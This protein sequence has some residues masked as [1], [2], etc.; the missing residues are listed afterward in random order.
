MRILLINGSPKG[1]QSST[2]SITRAFI[3]GM[4]SVTKNEVQYLDVMAN[5]IEYC[6]G[7]LSCMKN[8]G[9]CIHNDDMAQILRDILASELLLFS[10]PLYGFGVPAPLK[11]LLDR[12]LPLGSLAMR[13][14]GDRYEHVEQADF[15]HLRYAVISG[16]GF[17]NAKHN[18]DALR[19][20]FELRFPNG[21]FVLTVP[22]AP[23]FSAPE[24]AVVTVPFLDLVRQAG[25]EYALRGTV[26]D[27]LMG[28]LS[29]P[30][31]PEETYAAI[32]NG[33]A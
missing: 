26:S 3:D 29:V 11:A 22:E 20:Q 4:S 14:S 28:K 6:R 1:E 8:G 10:F 31:I 15:S 25:R 18:F 13:K 30:M 12:T 23:M 33:N 7:D 5:H 19:L 32:C 9:T 2:M 17:P 16:C 27:E 24:A 21:V